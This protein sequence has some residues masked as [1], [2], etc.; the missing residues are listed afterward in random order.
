[1]N[2]RKIVYIVSDS[3][4]ETAELMVKAVL[5]QFSGEDIEIQN[6]SYVEG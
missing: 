3:V 4:G 6:T 2:K 1:V 5:T